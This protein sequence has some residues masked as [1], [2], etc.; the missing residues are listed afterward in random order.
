MELSD[1][2]SEE[3]V[4]KTKKAVFANNG[5]IDCQNL[6][7][8]KVGSK[9]FIEC[10]VQVSSL[11][12]LEEAHALASEIEEELA[13]TFGNVEAT[14]HIEPAE[15]DTKVEKRV[16]KLVKIE[17]VKEVHDIITVYAHG[18]LYITLHINPHA[19]SVL[20]TKTILF[21]FASLAAEKAAPDIPV[22]GIT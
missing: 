17:N 2:A 3:L 21:Q 12:S 19:L 9:T 5:A 20:F 11:M 10:S 18:K 6:K 8:R 13:K 22:N 7:V 15:E 1:T 16:E 4:Q 14:I